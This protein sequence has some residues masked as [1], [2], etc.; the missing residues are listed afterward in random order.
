[1]S[2]RE[3]AKHFNISRDTVRKMVAYSAPPGYRRQS[4]VR[5]PKLDAFVATTD[6]W[7]DEDVKVPRKRRHTARRVFDRLREECGLTG[8]YTIIKD[9]M[10]ERDQR[11]QEVFVPLAH[12]P[13]H[14]QADSG[15]AMVMIGGVEQKA[16]FFVLD[17]PHSDGRLMCVPIRLPWRRH[18]STAT[19]MRSPSSG[20]CRSR[21]ST[22]VRRIRN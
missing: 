2:Q 1:M 14:A 12:P 13:G 16:H 19:S 21:S 15:E 5:R 7:L 10:R 9:Y 18:G 8:G 4:P 17:L 20:R 6:H 11:R 3:A 22:T